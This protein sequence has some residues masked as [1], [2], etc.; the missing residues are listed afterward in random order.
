MKKVLAITLMAVL[1][2]ACGSTAPATDDTAVQ[3]AVAALL[4]QQAPA[5]AGATEAPEEAPADTGS[6][7]PTSEVIPGIPAEATCVPL[8]TDRVVAR[9]VEV[10]SGDEVYVQIGDARYYVRYIGIDAGDNP[11]ALEAN[12]TLVE[13]QEVVLVRDVSDVDE[14]GR[15]LRYVMVGDAF[16]NLRLLQQRLV[17][18]S[19][20]SPDTACER[21][22]NSVP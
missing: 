3:T 13:N 2:A 5:P 11:A 7:I 20:E 14:Y 10:P 4:T 9:V 15:L 19:P 8:G 6:I 22:F 1:L 21:L 18:A 16:V 12:R 17:G